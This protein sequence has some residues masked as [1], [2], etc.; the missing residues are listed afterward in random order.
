MPGLLRRRRQGLLGSAPA[1]LVPAIAGNLAADL[2][3]SG[4]DAATFTRST[5]AAFT[6]YEGVL[7]MADINE[8]RFEGGR[9]ISEGVWSAVKPDG[10]PIYPAPKLLM[11]GQ[12]QNLC[13][14][15]EDLSNV[16]WLK[17]STTPPTID[18]NDRLSPSG[19][20]NADRITSIAGG[21][22]IQDVNTGAS[23][24]G[25]TF[26]LSF[27]V[28]TENALSLTLRM[29]G[30]RTVTEAENK[31]IAI[32]ANT[33]TKCVFTKSFVSADGNTVKIAPVLNMSIG[34]V[35]WIWGVQLEQSPVPTSYIP[36][37]ASPVTR[38]ADAC[39]WPLS[40]E[41]QAMLSIDKAWTTSYA[42]QTGLT[43][44]A[45]KNQSSFAD[46]QSWFDHPDKDLSAFANSGKMMILRDSGGR[47]AW[48][49]IGA[50]GTGQTLGSELLTNGDFSVWTG[51]NPDG[52]TVSESGANVI[53][54]TGN[55]CSIVSDGTSVS[56]SQPI[57]TT[58]KRYLTSINIITVYSGSVK[59]QYNGYDYGFNDNGVKTLYAVALGNNFTVA[60]NT[61]CNITIDDVSVKEVLT[62]SAKGVYIY[63]DAARTLQGWNME[64]SFNMN[65]SSYTFDVVNDC[66][67]EGTVVLD[68]VPG[69]ANTVVFST[70]NRV[71]YS[72]V[73]GE[74]FTRHSSATSGRLH[75]WDSTTQV[76][77][78]TSFVPAAGST[79]RA[80]LRF[81]TDRRERKISIIA[82]GIAMHGDSGSFDGKFGIGTAL[83]LNRLGS[84]VDKYSGLR[85]FKRWLTDSELLRLQ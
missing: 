55:A 40:S 13:L 57:L 5:T 74:L 58:K 3:V 14:W 71:L 73:D 31:I 26:T 63:K 30:T 52:W 50:A 6:D 17:E 2:T 29:R 83:E 35:L 59:V 27:W 28:Y 84:L 34:W 54:Q 20:V 46:N 49:F 77:S 82:A 39:S 66:K 67:A 16:L 79:Y 8:P 42:N 25:K 10:S 85:F 32:P 75:T 64:A 48:G 9:R 15:S 72:G 1:V 12:G 11:E 56:I 7:R 70:S 23:I 65:D 61:A 21:N 37:G 69:Y 24:A 38:T 19:V 18:I 41:L 44:G 62:P 43:W 81:S 60:R 4:L 76:N 33:W 80:V 36:T 51:D 78:P 47:L 53:T 68:W 45:D 22:I